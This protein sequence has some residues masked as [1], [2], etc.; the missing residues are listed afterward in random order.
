MREHAFYPIAPARK[1]RRTS[2]RLRVPLRSPKA[3]MKAE[4]RLRF[5]I[6]NSW[7]HPRGVADAPEVVNQE[8]GPGGW[9]CGL[10]LAGHGA[11]SWMEFHP[12]PPASKDEAVLLQILR[13][14]RCWRSSASA[15]P[16]RDNQ[17]I[18]VSEYIIPSGRVE[19]VHVRERD[20]SAQWPWPDEPVATWLIPP[21]YLAAA[22]SRRRS[23]VSH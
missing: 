3:G 17:P 8:P 7:I 22:D 4:R 19:T 15:G 11:I 14:F 16:G 12:R 18:E 23:A 20:E 13:C 6:C 5:Q 2:R 9:L 1:A 10:E 21:L